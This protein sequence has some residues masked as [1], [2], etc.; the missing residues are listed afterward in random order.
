MTI[1]VY[2]SVEPCQPAEIYD[3]HG[4]TIEQFVASQ[5]EGYKRGKDQKVYCSINGQ[6]VDPLD[7]PATVIG[8][9]DLVEFRVKPFGDALGFVFPFWGGSVA[10]GQAALKAIV[11][12][13]KPGTQGSGQQG[14]Q[15]EPARAKANTA[16]A[17]AVAPQLFGRH[18]R[19]PDYLNQPRRYY[20]DKETQVL[21]M[22]LAV[23]VGDLDLEADSVKIGETPVSELEGVTYQLF[24]PG[25]DV[26]GVS[27]HEN[28]YSAPEIS[29]T[30]NANGVRLR[31]V[32]YDERT[33]I[34]SATGSGKDLTGVSVGE[35][36]EAGIEGPIKL[37]Q[38]VSVGDPGNGDPNTFTGNFQHLGGSGL[39][40]DIESNV[41]VNGTYVISSISPDQTVIELETTGGS[42]VEGISPR[43]G[44]MAIDRAGTKYRLTAISGSTITVDRILESNGNVD[45]GW[46][47]NPQTGLTVEIEWEAATFT[48]KRTGPF[49]ACPEGETTDKLEVDI[50]CPSGLGV[51][52][53][54]SINSRSRTIRIEWREAGTS[55]YTV[56]NETVT[57]A[58]RDQL[59]FTFTVNLPSAIRPEVRISR[60]GAEDVSVTSLDRLEVTGLR[61]KLPTRTSYPDLTTMAVTIV[62]SDEIGSQSEN[63][64]NLI[65]TRK[66]EPVG[67][68]AARAT[69]SIADAVYY[70]AKSANYPDERIDIA[71]LQRLDAIWSSRGDYFDFVFQETTLQEAMNTALRAGFAE[72]TVENGVL[73]PVRD[74]PRTQFE[75]PYSPENMLAPLKRN[76]ETIRPDEF[77]GVEVE[78]FDA[79]TWTTETVQCLLAGDQGIKLDKIKLDGVTDRTRAWRIGMR[80]RRSQRYRRWTYNF[81]TELDALNSNYLSYVPLVDDIPGYGKAS[82]L[83]AMD[84][85]GATPKLIVNQPM[86]WEDGETH[87]VAYRDVNGDLIGPFT[88]TQG[89]TDYEIIA[90]V[91]PLPELSPMQ[92]PPHVFFGTTARWSFPALITEISPQGGLEIGVTATNYDSRVYD[93]DDNAPG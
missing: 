42:P 38:S 23:T 74:E 75:Q 54:E 11:D 72:L 3:Q 4:M 80:R 36:W 59:G 84:T 63:R 5:A 39:T 89:D 91:D 34:G 92:E 65:G 83:R 57:G 51:V 6:N 82:V 27:N 69:R 58:T 10:V 61:A 73:V 18:I 45:P 21:K 93:D 68:G 77:D 26:S 29:A 22:F 64:V 55:T 2:P 24:A 48:A 86:D 15:I 53:G 13:P 1:K 88:A 19:F 67:G 32:T 37:T 16:R 71:E 30:N 35:L 9:H 40:V 46:S 8:E 17:G 44:T 41:G 33:Y 85:S 79:A 78:Y 66:L 76:F 47:A 28:W 62:G 81:T 70:M 25:A 49:T 87:V 56:Q 7:W 20:Q 90:D 12:V 52:D 31:G 50:F 43:S 60:I 14:A